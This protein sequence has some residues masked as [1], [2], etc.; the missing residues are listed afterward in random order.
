LE[1]RLLRL[2]RE[3][4]LFLIK[5]ERQL[6]YLKGKRVSTRKKMESGEA[7]EWKWIL[8]PTEVQIDLM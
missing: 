1:V 8:S 6:V 5:M 3:E 4:F 2:R 7:M